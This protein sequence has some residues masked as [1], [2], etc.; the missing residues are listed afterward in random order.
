MVCDI[1]AGDGKIGN[2][3][4]TVYRV[5]LFHNLFYYLV[6]AGGFDGKETLDSVEVKINCMGLII[7]APR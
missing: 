2:L 7:I 3:F 1:P 6:A 4:S 5:K